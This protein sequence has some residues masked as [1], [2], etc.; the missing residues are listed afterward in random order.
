MAAEAI[1][2]LPDFAVL[3]GDGH[4]PLSPRMPSRLWTAAV[5]HADT[6]GEGRWD[7]LKPALPAVV[8]RL[9]D[10]VWMERFVACFEALA[11]RLGTR[12]FDSSRLASCTAERRWRCTWS[13]TRLRTEPARPA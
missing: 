9:A 3:Y 12:E 7:L 1:S 8:Q 11:R 5:L 6:Y 10:E 4:S 2:D 13:S